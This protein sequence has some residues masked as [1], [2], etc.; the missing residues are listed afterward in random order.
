MTKEKGQK[1]IN[2]S[3]VS[4]LA[5]LKKKNYL[6]IDQFLSDFYFERVKTPKSFLITAIISYDFHQ[7]D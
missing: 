2:N 6:T 4:L 5:M 1:Q 3:P 7:C